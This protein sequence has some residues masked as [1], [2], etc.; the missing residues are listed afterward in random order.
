[1]FVHGCFWHGHD[2]VK[3]KQRPKSNAD[4]WALKL[5]GN[6]QRDL[7][8]QERLRLLGWIVQ[9]MWECDLE[10]DIA[11]LLGDLDNDRNEVPPGSRYA[12]QSG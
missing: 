9:V 8:N 12:S 11:K 10:S 6:I 3:G 2:C 7:L 5:N 1:V 4:F